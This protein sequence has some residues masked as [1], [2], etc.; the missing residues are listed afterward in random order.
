MKKLIVFVF[1]VAIVVAFIV[2][3]LAV[4]TVTLYSLE[5][6]GYLVDSAAVAKFV[7]DVN[8]GTLTG[9]DAVNTWNALLRAGKE[10]A[11]ELKKGGVDA[12]FLGKAKVK[13][14]MVKILPKDDIFYKDPTGKLNKG[15]VKFDKLVVFKD[16]KVYTLPTNEW[17]PMA[18]I[19][20]LKSSPVT[21]IINIE[22]LSTGGGNG[23]SGGGGNGGGGGGTGGGHGG[24]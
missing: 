18:D 21:A 2:P 12:R 4:E 11:N 19:D 1:A 24:S 15:Y 20:A 23:G 8:A 5:I 6:R 17:I 3:S 16:G 22:T 14:D 13:G 10:K 9:D 7:D